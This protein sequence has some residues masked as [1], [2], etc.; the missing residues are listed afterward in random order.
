MEEEGYW[1]RQGVRANLSKAQKESLGNPTMPRP[2]VDVVGYSP[3]R[4]ELVFLEVKSLLDSRGVTLKGLKHWYQRRP[5]RYKLLNVPRYQAAVTK[6]ILREYRRAGLVTGRIRIRVGL[7]A[8]N[9]PQSER[10]AVRIFAQDQ[11]WFYLGPEQITEGI[12][13]LSRGPYE[14]SAVILAAKLLRQNPEGV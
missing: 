10:S 12:R 3:K 2:Q 1:V 6:A 9:V 5:N 8:G 14:E 13:R 11:G 7:A 4:R